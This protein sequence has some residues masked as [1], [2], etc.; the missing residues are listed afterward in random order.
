ME[1]SSDRPVD[2]SDEFGQA[3]EIGIIKQYAQVL[4]LKMKPVKVGFQ[5]EGKEKKFFIYF[6]AK[7][8]VDFR[9]LVKRLYMRYRCRIEMRQISI[10]EHAQMLGAGINT[11]PHSKIP[12]FIPW[13]QTS[14]FGGCFYDKEET[15]SKYKYNEDELDV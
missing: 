6:I 4:G 9:E 3:V 2:V 14:R 11:C 13:C 1:N 12:C 7:K 10:R 15:E 8:R 5:G